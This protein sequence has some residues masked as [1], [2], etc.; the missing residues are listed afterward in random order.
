MEVNP[1]RNIMLR[2]GTL[3]VNDN[4]T[5][6]LNAPYDAKEIGDYVGITPPFGDFF[7]HDAGFFDD[8]H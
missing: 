1:T 6:D 3:G 2:F 5:G 7:D 8:L 4:T